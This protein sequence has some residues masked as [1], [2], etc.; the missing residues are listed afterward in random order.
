MDNNDKYV[1][2]EKLNRKIENKKRGEILYYSIDQVA[3][4][5]NE[6]SGNIKYYTNIFDGLLKIE[7]L[8]KELRYTNTDVDKLEFLIK[9][10]NR[11]MSLKEIQDY[12]TKLPLD[13]TEVEHTASNLIS[14]EDLIDSIKK[15]QQSQLNDFKVQLINDIQSANSLYLK[16]ITSTIVEAQNKNL[17]EFKLNL[18]EEIKEY[19]N[20]KFDKVNE[21]NINLHNELL[22]NTTEFISEKIES[23][24]NELKLNLQNDFNSFAQ[25][26]LTRSERLLKEVK[27]FKRVIESAYYTQYEVEMDNANSGFFSKLLQSIRL[28]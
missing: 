28:K 11:G 27:D 24:N 1:S 4:L 3:D 20:S 9:L 19:I 2:S 8:D 21:T 23:K 25:S 7:I 14:V 22:A 26:S 12:C 18:Y 13:D 10:K 17:N 5:L 15:E 6:S 16:D